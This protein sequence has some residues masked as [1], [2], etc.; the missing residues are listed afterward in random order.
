MN[1]YLYIDKFP[2]S[3]LSTLADLESLIDSRL[4]ERCIISPMVLTTRVG[5]ADDDI[6][7]DL[8]TVKAVLL[9]DNPF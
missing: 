1:V 2:G 4:S 7:N 3:Q 5:Y 6:Y 9:I 8:I